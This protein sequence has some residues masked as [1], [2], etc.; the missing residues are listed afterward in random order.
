MPRA[1]KVI[2]E[3]W[4]AQSHPVEGWVFPSLSKS[5]HF[6]QGSAKN[7][8]AK[9]LEISEVDPIEPYTLRHTALTELGEHRDPCTLA[10]IAGHSSITI[11]ERYVHPQAAAIERAF[12]KM[13]D[14][15]QLVTSGGH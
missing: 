5:G 12:K 8:H 3:R 4:E 13:V 9:A 11:T 6:N 14:R 15:H 2:K 1:Y 7:Q 10:R